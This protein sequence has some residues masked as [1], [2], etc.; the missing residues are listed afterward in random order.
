MTTLGCPAAISTT[1]AC[2]FG[3][4]LDIVGKIGAGTGYISAAAGR[5]FGSSNA[6]SRRFAFASACSIQ[7]RALGES[8]GANVIRA[9]KSSKDDK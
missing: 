6:N 9:D 1:P 8:T 7:D 5:A 2:G 4:A 3:A